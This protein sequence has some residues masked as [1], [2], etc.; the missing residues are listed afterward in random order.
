[1]QIHPIEGSTNVL[2]AGYDERTKTL[3]IKFTNATYHYENVERDRYEAFLRSHS[4][5]KF[6]HQYI[7][8][9]HK[10]VKQ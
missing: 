5:G 8:P 7:K 9:N 10:G 4:K 1:M 6:F 3:A 2:G